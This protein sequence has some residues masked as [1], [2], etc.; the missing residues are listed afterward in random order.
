MEKWKQQFYETL[1]IK[2]NVEIRKKYISRTW[3]ANWTAAKDEV[4]EI[5]TNIKE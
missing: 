1:N 4:W 3:R 2:D 5:I